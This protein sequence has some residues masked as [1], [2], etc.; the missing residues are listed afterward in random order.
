ME[1]KSNEIYVGPS[2][3]KVALEKYKKNFSSFIP[4]LM[5][6]GLILVCVL[7]LAFFLDFSLLFTVPLFLCPFFFGFQLFLVDQSENPTLGKNA[8]WYFAPKFSGSYNLWRSFLYSL[9]FAILASILVSSVYSVIASRFDSSYV[10]AFN[11]YYQAAMNGDIA[12][13]N[14]MLADSTNPLVIMTNVIGIVFYTMLCLVF[15]HHLFKRGAVPYLLEKFPR[16]MGGRSGNALLSAYLKRRGRAFRKD[17]YKA[18]WLGIVLLFVGFVLGITL[19]YIFLPESLTFSLNSKATLCV[20][21]GLI[22]ACLLLL[23]YF[24]YYCYVEKELV[25]RYEKDI[26]DVNAELNKEALEYLKRLK[27]MNDLQ[28]RYYEDAI[29]NSEFEKDNDPEKEETEEEDEQK[30]DLDDYGRGDHS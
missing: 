19:G 29:R 16:L 21:L 20:V 17:Y 25:D 4:F 23:F 3:S 30:N 18:N 24:P 13:I 1:N 22:A 27:E 9:G 8:K 7:A 11:S 28:A 5:A 15:C 6:F 12:T 26:L 14:S 2:I 10:E